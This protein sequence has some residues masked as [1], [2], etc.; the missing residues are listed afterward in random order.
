MVWLNSVNLLKQVH[1]KV[2][3]M[4]LEVGY[5]LKRI[6]CTMQQSCLIKC[7]KEIVCSGMSWLIGTSFSLVGSSTWISMF[8]WVSWIFDF[9]FSSVICSGYHT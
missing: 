5:M 6:V 3:L 2:R 7:L 1:E 4:D 8:D 9:I